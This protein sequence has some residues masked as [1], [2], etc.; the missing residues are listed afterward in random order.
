MNFYHSGLDAAV[1]YVALFHNWICYNFSLIQR[2]PSGMMSFSYI[3]P[4]SSS[5]ARKI[6]SMA[7][8]FNG[9]TPAG[10]VAASLGGLFG[11]GCG[12]NVD[13]SLTGAPLWMK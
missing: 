9:N 11:L 12:A 1:G 8:P 2:P 6:Q 10:G 3:S 5:S 4:S 13:M 7:T